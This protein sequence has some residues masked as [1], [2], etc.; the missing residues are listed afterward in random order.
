LDLRSSQN[1][2]IC[3]PECRDEGMLVN[4]QN[5]IEEQDKK[6]LV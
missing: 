4:L 6:E 2:P 1:N 3:D 5:Y